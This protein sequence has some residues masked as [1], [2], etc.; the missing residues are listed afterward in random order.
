MSPRTTARRPGRPRAQDAPLSVD[1]MLKAALGAFAT[2]GYDGM[3]VSA[4]SR[5]LGVSHNLLHQRFG[6]KEGLWYAAVDWGFGGLAD[7][8]A[9]AADPTLSDPLEQLAVILRR[10][11]EVSAERPELV[12]LMNIEG[13]ERSARLTFLYDHYVEPLTAPIGRLLEHLAAAGRVPADLRPGVPLPRR[14]RC[15]RPVHAPGAR[16]RARSVGSVRPGRAG[17]VHRRRRGRAD[18]GD[19]AESRRA[20]L[21]ITRSVACR[22]ARRPDTVE[23]PTT[24][25]GSAR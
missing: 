12:G 23:R 20:G 4:L 5:E 7:E 18:R 21:N 3:S 14:A 22:P 1:D 24:P 6:S 25:P 16:A 11:L 10:F 13:R 19:P 8:L 15:S 17:R 9:K 2:H